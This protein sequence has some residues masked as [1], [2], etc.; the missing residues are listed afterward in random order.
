MALALVPACGG[1]GDDDGGGGT[2]SYP[3]DANVLLSSSRIAALSTANPAGMEAPVSVTGLIAG[4]VLVAIDRR[5]LNGFLYGLGFNSAAGTV[6]I[7]S[8][9]SPPKPA[10]S[11]FR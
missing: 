11:E 3:I 6:Q 2:P 4:D 9:S 5:P 1:G 8:V 7:Y 10:P